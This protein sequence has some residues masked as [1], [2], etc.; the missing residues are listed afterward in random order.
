MRVA[1]IHRLKIEPSDKTCLVLSEDTTMKDKHLAVRLVDMDWMAELDDAIRTNDGELRIICPFIKKNMLEHILMHY[2]G[3]IKT[4]TRFNLSD[5]AA[6]VSDIESLRM[7][8]NKQAYVRGV[9]N[10]HAKLY[11]FGNRRVMLTSANLTRAAFS[12]NHELGIISDDSGVIDTCREYFENLWRRSGPDLQPDQVES[13]NQKITDYHM[14]GGKPDPN[15]ELG[16]CGMDVGID[17]LALS[18]EPVAFDDATQAFIKFLGQ[19]SNRRLLSHKIVK[20]LK[21]SDCHHV[22]CYPKKKRPRTVKDG[23]VMF[24]A[25]MTKQPND[26]RIFGR[27]IGMKHQEER[28][29]ATEDEV[30]RHNW[31]RKWP[32]YIRIHH[33]EFVAGTLEN[34]VSFN[35]LIKTS[36]CIQ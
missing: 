11:L 36:R 10:L 18:P 7:L 28:D 23:A 22:L 3:S 26:M 25:R 12:G 1:Q 9:R 16:D 32:R 29:N 35:E 17:S 19:S 27:A 13:W 21:R 15:E 31:K 8:L 2:T 14:S 4:I 5:F 33:A 24:I 30:K 34:G 6:G 20:T